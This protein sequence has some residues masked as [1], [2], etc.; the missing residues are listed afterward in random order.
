MQ[1]DLFSQF[2]HDAV[3]LLDRGPP[4]EA[5][6]GRAEEDRRPAREAV[7]VGR[8]PDRPRLGTGSRR[9][10]SCAARL[11]HRPRPSGSA[12]ISPT[13]C[14][15]SPT[16]RRW[17]R[18]TRAPRTPG[19]RSSAPS[20]RSSRRASPPARSTG[21]RTCASPDA[22]STLKSGRKDVITG[23]V[24]PEDVPPK[25][26]KTAEKKASA[27]AAAATADA[28]ASAPEAAGTKPG[29][30]RRRA[31][32]AAAELRRAVRGALDDPHHAEPREPRG[33]ARQD[34]GPEHGRHRRTSP[35]SARAS[36]APRWPS[37]S[38]VAFDLAAYLLVMD[39]STR[40]TERPADIRLVR[41]S[42]RPMNRNSEN[43]FA[44]ASPG[45]K[46]D[47]PPAGKWMKLGDDLKRFEAF[48]ALPDAEKHEPVRP[49]G[50][51][52]ALQPG[53]QPAP[54][55]CRSGNAWSSC[56]TS[57]SPGRS[58]PPRSTSGSG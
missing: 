46:L 51:G 58:G 9:C 13:R 26:K 31:R 41:T 48:R 28:P 15:T 38:D 42:L 20:T 6:R 52:R 30:R 33:Q 24:L 3:Y 40:G 16:A 25:P 37:A 39:T 14:R 5:R 53:R 1:R 32:R 7:E 4:R 11:G 49:R 27:A 36:S 2:D 23:L 17:T 45:E 56:S 43:D 18:P 34:R 10:T 47:S 29:G 19:A 57:T 50:L 44:A 8:D 12:T 21:P 22:S 55:A 54:R 35:R